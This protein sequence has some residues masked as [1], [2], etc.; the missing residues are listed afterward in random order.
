MLN[1][2]N[3]KMVPSNRSMGSQQQN[4]ANV[5]ENVVQDE[6]QDPL[7]DEEVYQQGQMQE[8]VIQEGGI[9]ERGDQVQNLPSGALPVNQ[10]QDHAPEE[11]QGEVQNRN[12]EQ[13]NINGVPQNQG[14]NRNLNVVGQGQRGGD[15]RDA[16][17]RGRGGHGR[18]VPRGRGGYGR[19]VPIGQRSG[20]WSA[21]SARGRV[22][23]YG[24]AAPARGQGGYGQGVPQ[25]SGIWRPYNDPRNQG[26]PSNYLGP[27]VQEWLQQPSQEQNNTFSQ[28]P[29]VQAGLMAPIAQNLWPPA[30]GNYNPSYFASSQVQGP[31]TWQS[32]SGGYP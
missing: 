20:Y 24:N 2:E 32:A 18:G 10:E 6:F 26:Q 30:T 11:K 17:A 13:I 21:A 8:E 7:Q 27:S 15:G 19:G 25:R 31:P 14:G 22:G 23:G 5:P 12:E 16:P 3:R 29:P 1:A 4:Y 28:P 9:D